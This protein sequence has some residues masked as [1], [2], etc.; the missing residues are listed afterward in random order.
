MKRGLLIAL[1]V[2]AV[3][4]VVL[5][6][7]SY[8][9]IAVD[10]LGFMEDQPSVRYQEGPRLLS[11]EDAV[12]FYQPSY[13]NSP[14][15]LSNPVPADDVSLQRGGMLF[16]LHCSVCHGTGGQGDGPVTKF[17]KAEARRPAN[18][19]APSV[20]QF[21]DALLYQVITQGIGGMPPM[22]ESFPERQVWDVI[23]FVRTLSK[24]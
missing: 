12:S 10:W 8:E 22:R 23:N 14:A 21:P 2:V 17:W 9:I 15:T 19:T 5:L 24:P 11:P 20:G 6:L 18:L 13:H 16:G 1:A 7:F 4:V 3:A